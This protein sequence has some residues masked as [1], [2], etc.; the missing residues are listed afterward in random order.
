MNHSFSDNVKALAAMPEWEFCIV[1]GEGFFSEICAGT[2]RNGV[3]Y[4]E[5]EIY[6]AYWIR[7]PD[8]EAL[9]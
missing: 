7:N 5:Q 1:M 8:A 9:V 4:S 3:Y 2:T 6:A